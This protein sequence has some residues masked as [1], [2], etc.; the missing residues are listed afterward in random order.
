MG[1]EARC[2]PSK[3]AAHCCHMKRQPFLCN[4]PRRH[5]HCHCNCLRHLHRRCQLRR[6]CRCHPHCCR[7][8]R[9]RCCCRR[10]YRCRRNCN[11]QLLL[12][13][14]STI[15]VAVAIN[16]CHRHLC[17]VAISHRCCHRPCHWPLLPPSPLTIPV[18]IAVNHH[19]CYAVGHFQELL[20]WRGKNCIQ[21]IEAKN[22]YLILFCSD[23]GWCI[24]RS[25]MTDQVSRGNGQHQCWAAS[26][27]Q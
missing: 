15:A 18:A 13:L 20:P 27:K 21:P 12:P 6:C 16:H 23:S 19:R 4:G 9:C 7:R 2:H 17:P 24:D 5:G 26:G 3:S 1:V 22:A 8:C 10:H 11:R 14:P 25:R